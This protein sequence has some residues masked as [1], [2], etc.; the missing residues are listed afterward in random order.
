MNRGEGSRTLSVGGPGGIRIDG[1]DVGIAAASMLRPA[2]NAPHAAHAALT[3]TASFDLA[4]APGALAR[5]PRAT[6]GA[7]AVTAIAGMSAAAAVI[8]AAHLPWLFL[9][10]PAT[11]AIALLVAAA[12]TVTSARKRIMTAGV[13][14]ELEKRLLDLAAESG[15]A[16]TV[17]TV[18]RALSIPMAEAETT[19]SA[20][21]REGHVTVENEPTTGVVVYVF[22]EIQAARA[23]TRRSA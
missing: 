15:G 9:A 5:Y 4:R 14:P 6:T 11:L 7:L 21:A 12:A 10:A 20:L 22:P 19:L 8:S 23:R 17:T 2:E 1:D 13:D 18:A 16:V 3:P